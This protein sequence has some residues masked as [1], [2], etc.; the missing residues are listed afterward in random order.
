M[1][2]LSFLSSTKIKCIYSSAGMCTIV[3]VPLKISYIVHYIV[4]SRLWSEY[5][6]WFFYSVSR[7]FIIVKKNVIYYVFCGNICWW[8]LYFYI[9]ML[10]ADIKYFILFQFVLFCSVFSFFTFIRFA[11][12]SYSFVHIRTKHIFLLQNIWRYM[13]VKNLIEY[14][15]T[16]WCAL[17]Y[18]EFY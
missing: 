2:I 4:Y 12:E 5:A 8:Y 15:K 16:E 1:N 6:V 18:Y 11:H 13:T 3:A 14:L 10:R 17:R 7:F 9:R